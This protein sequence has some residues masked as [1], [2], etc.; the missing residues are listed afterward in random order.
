MC[1]FFHFSNLF[2]CPT[3]FT[4]LLSLSLSLALSVCV[5]FFPNVSQFILVFFLRLLPA[6]SYYPGLFS[7]CVITILC[8]IGTPTP[9]HDRAKQMGRAEG[10]G[11]G[12]DRDWATMCS[13]KKEEDSTG[14]L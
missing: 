11:Q 12:L 6:S 9:R 4:C 5:S 3:S 1:L 2:D 10:E 7:F 13:C 8:P 14:Y